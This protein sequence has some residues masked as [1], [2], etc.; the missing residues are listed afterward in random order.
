MWHLGIVLA[1]LVLVAGVGVMAMLS[2]PDMSPVSPP[3]APPRPELPAA[4]AEDAAP[5][6][7]L[8]SESDAPADAG[9]TA[10][11]QHVAATASGH[12]PG[13]IW[14]DAPEVART[15]ETN[16]AR[17]LDDVPSREHDVRTVSVHEDRTGSSLDEGS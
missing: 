11:P 1:A 14:L 3:S 13:T 10:V 17:N 2:E 9:D 4:V 6:D 12:P 8:P 15:R 5:E 7:E 16:S